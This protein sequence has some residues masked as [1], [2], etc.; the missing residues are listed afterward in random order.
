MAGSVSVTASLKPSAAP[1]PVI[2]MPMVEID[3]LS[4]WYGAKIALKDI[5][6][7]VAKH[8]ITAYIGRPAAASPRSSGA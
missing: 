4:L 3:H 7:S 5:S 6:M 1:A 2:E 8:R